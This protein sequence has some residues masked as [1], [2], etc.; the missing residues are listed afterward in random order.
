M[1]LELIEEFSILFGYIP[2]RFW[3]CI[4]LIIFCLYIFLKDIKQ[5]KDNDNDEDNS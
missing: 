2:L 3:F 1:K 4:F 5:Y